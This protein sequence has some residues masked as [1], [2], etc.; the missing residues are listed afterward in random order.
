MQLVTVERG[1]RAAGN[2][3]EGFMCSWEQSGEVRVQLG[4][5]DR[6]VHVQLRRVVR[7]SRAAGNSR[8][9]FMCSCEQS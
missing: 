9:R 1:S 4:T 7:G 6:E 5:V 2:S 8:E 3:R